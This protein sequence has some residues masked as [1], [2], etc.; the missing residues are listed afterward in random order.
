MNLRSFILTISIVFGCLFLA[1]AKRVKST[2][3]NTVPVEG[4]FLYAAQTEVSNIQYKEFLSYIKK[5]KGEDA[6]WEM[7]PDTM[8]WRKSTGYCEPFVDCYLNHSAYKD[9]PVVGVSKYQAMAYC[10]WLTEIL[11]MNM[12]K[13]Y[14]KIQV[15][16]PLK[17]EW[18]DAARGGHP[19]YNLP[20]GVNKYR[21]GPGDKR[22][23]QGSFV[24]NF[25]ANAISPYGV[26]GGMITTPVRSYWKNDYGLYNM[27]GN[28]AEMVLDD[29]IVKG[30]SWNSTGYFIQIDA[31]EY[32][33]NSNNPSNEVGFRYFIEVME[34][35]EEPSLID[36]RIKIN[37]AHRNIVLV[38]T[39]LY[40]CENECTNRSY[41]RFAFEFPEYASKDSNWLLFGAKEYFKKYSWHSDYSI[42]PVVNVTY[43][44]ASKYCE[45]LSERYNNSP[46]KKYQK[47]KFRLPTKEEWENAANGGKESNMYP[48]GGP[49]MRNN[50]GIHL[51]N[52]NPTPQQ[53]KKR[54]ARMV[55]D[56]LEI[57]KHIF[58]NL[59]GDGSKYTC[60]VGSH[61]PN[62]FGLYNCSGNAAEMT[63][64]KG[65]AKGGSWGSTGY[66]LRL[67]MDINQDSSYFYSRVYLPNSE[68]SPFLGFRY[69]MEVLEY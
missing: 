48:W 63:S 43:E 10:N 56:Q 17:K 23:Y 38:D 3:P 57:N 33:L 24:C 15:R 20:N 44:A 69:F 60:W 36:K 2:F 27:S 39:N 47:V 49:Y 41:R 1:E 65:L 37:W 12:P 29:T 66:Y 68:T 9:Y 19:E 35:D 32:G 14:K 11:S 42:H 22:K 59:D 25:N 45:W 16:L 61:F 34:Y 64:T 7:H 6:Y 18:E 55:T 52:Y 30:G 31:D 67:D 58:D 8:I 5:T 51:A 40:A 28:V 21:M 53:F 46:K 13:G 50:R 54:N 62:D 4:D 26:N